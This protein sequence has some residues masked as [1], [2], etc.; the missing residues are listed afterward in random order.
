[1]AA[2]CF[3]VHMSQAL[4]DDV[5]ALWDSLR[6]TFHLPPSPATH[7]G[8]LL[9]LLSSEVCFV[10][11]LSLGL[12]AQGQARESPG[13]CSPVLGPTDPDMSTDILC[14]MM[15]FYSYDV[16]HTCGPDPK[17]CC[18]FDFKRLPGGRINCPWKVPPRAI[19]DAN[20][21]ER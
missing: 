5:S 11:P 12:P 7:W 16:P 14:H 2:S 19:T 10:R 9:C 1:M 3:S 4:G 13:W 18:Q 8:R 6:V 21:A 15:P 20:V 17:I